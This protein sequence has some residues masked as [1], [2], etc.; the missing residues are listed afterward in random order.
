MGILRLNCMGRLPGQE[1]PA[2]FFVLVF[3][4]WQTGKIFG[5]V[6]ERLCLTLESE[7]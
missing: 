7:E 2:L 5:L 1:Q 3:S 6:C 4:S